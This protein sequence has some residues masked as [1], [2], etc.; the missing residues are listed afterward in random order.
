MERE[1]E[2]RL[3]KISVENPD[4]GET[5][6]FDDY[7]KAIFTTDRGEFVIHWDHASQELVV[8][9][10]K[11]EEDVLIRPRAVNRFGVQFKGD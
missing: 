8:F 1:G 10:R 6:G 7:A 5:L 3:T 2:M 4:T 9:A 11:A